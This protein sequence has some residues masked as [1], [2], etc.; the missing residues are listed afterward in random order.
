MARSDRS[1]R[2]TR[3]Q[4]RATAWDVGPEGFTGSLSAT[5]QIVFATGSQAVVSGLTIVRIRGAL[6][7]F[8]AIAPSLTNH[9]DWFFGMCIINENAFGVGLTATPSPLADIGWDGWLM[10]QMGTIGIGPSGDA[11]TS[12]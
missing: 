7:F 12:G 6:R 5:Q 8:Q 3:T 10:H 1:F 2:G 9:V 4:R 11:L